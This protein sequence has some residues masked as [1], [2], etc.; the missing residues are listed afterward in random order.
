MDNLFYVPAERILFWI[1]GYTAFNNTSNLA[2]KVRSLLSVGE[3]FSRGVG[4][5]LEQVK[6]DL[7]TKSS[8]YKHMQ[9]F[10]L[11]GAENHPDAFEL[12]GHWTMWEWIE[13]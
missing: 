10:W 4:G 3:K 1:T 6:T 12:N 11:E 8:R 2:D 5:D 9:V 7:I 13:N